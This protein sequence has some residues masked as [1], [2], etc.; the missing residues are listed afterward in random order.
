MG[1]T[2]I[3]SL[4]CAIIKSLIL[5]PECFFMTAFS[6]QAMVSLKLNVGFKIF[7]KRTWKDTK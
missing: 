7:W 2:K 1:N 6:T 5:N 3:N 4:D